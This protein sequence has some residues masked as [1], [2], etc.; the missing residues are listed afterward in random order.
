MNRTAIT[1][2]LIGVL[3]VTSGAAA[4]AEAPGGL[5]SARYQAFLVEAQR[6]RQA[7]GS[8]YGS[9][10]LHSSLTSEIGREVSWLEGEEA[11][12]EWDH[13]R[14]SESARN[15]AREGDL[16]RRKTRLLELDQESLDRELQPLNA[17]ETMWREQ[18]AEHDRRALIHN[19]NP[20]SGDDAAAATAY[21]QTAMAGN[22]EMKRISGEIERVEAA[23]AQIGV[24]REAL[25]ARAAELATRDRYLERTRQVFEA[26]ADRFTARCE[27]AI[28]RTRTLAVI[29]GSK[30]AN[31]IQGF[32]RNY[33]PRPN[34]VVAVLQSFGESA[35]L[36]VLGKLAVRGT[37][38]VG[39]AI[40]A[41]DLLTPHVTRGEEDVHDRLLLVGDYA[42]ALKRLKKQGRL[43][44]GDPDYQALRRMLERTG[45]QMPG[46]PAAFLAQSTE[47]SA[48]LK[49]G[50]ETLAKGYVLKKVLP[51]SGQPGVPL[52]REGN[53]ISQQGARVFKAFELEVNDAA[54][55]KPVEAAWDAIRDKT[56]KEWDAAGRRVAA[57]KGS[58][59]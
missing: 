58:S 56:K 6:V 35:A 49:D 53:S 17:E 50:L 8:V 28:D 42:A 37:G 16:L 46:S 4:R 13:S 2:S 1:G 51:D 20:P 59:R 10:W 30:P 55:E 41:R 26:D 38:A 5:W 40:T 15:L 39:L 11:R 45:K 57:R 18:L 36:G 29:A 33:E 47:L 48:L 14:L 44:E 12:L 34:A 31:L 7:L 3:L 9:G 54:N 24:R 21:N 43:D 19:D 25:V 22:A 32:R 27:D 52:A 23:K